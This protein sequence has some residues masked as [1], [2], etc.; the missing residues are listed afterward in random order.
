MS[1]PT[2]LR[3]QVVPPAPSLAGYVEHF[4][5]VEAPAPAGSHRE[6]LIPNGRPTVLVCLAAP[7]R[8]IAVDGAKVETN[9]SNSAGL[10]TRPLIL[11]QRGVSR[12]VAA[13]LQPW[14]LKAFGLPPLIDAVRPLSDWLGAPAA[15][16]LESACGAH[17]FGADAARP[18]QALLEARLDP[19]P[20]G[21]LD[22]L[23]A[24]LERIEAEKGL[25]GIDD[26]AA[27]LGIGYDTLYRLFR[28]H[29]GVPAKRFLSIMRFYYFTG[30]LLKGGFGSLALLANLQGY[31][32]QAH[33]TR[34]FRRFTGIS[35]TDFRHTLNGIA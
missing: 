8:R 28:S 4:W 16:E 22:R 11:E 1:T 23:R 24:A 21:R 12:Y 25:L 26:L 6:I 17:G 13:Q 7:G 27:G 31:Y 14:G 32:D 18:L 2:R 15:R 35:Q 5:M 19:F 29:V 30:E 3:Y 34:E 20:S 9:A 33:A 10:L